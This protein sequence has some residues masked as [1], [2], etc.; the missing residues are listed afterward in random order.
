[1]S[2][3]DPNC[4][5]TRQ[6]V[7]CPSNVVPIGHKW[8]FKLKY[9]PY[10]LYLEWHNA[11]IV[12]KGFNQTYRINYFDIIPIVNPIQFIFVYTVLTLTMSHGLLVQQ[13]DGHNTFLMVTW[14]RMI[15]PLG[16]EVSMVSSHMIKLT[17]TLYDLEQAPL[18]FF[19]IKIYTVPL[20]SKADNSL[21]MFNSAIS[22]IIILINVDDIL[23]TSDCICPYLVK[24]L[25]SQLNVQ[26][27]L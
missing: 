16:F 26:F 10:D 18:S 5:N 22:I 20:H 25:F 13:L 27:A 1:M 8:G 9:M 4:N 19:N 6:L 2:F 24:T 12:A 17:K 23:V 21:F 11:R 15:Q 7:P 3:L 14:Q